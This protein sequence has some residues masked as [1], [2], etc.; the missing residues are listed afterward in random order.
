MNTIRFS[1]I[2]VSQPENPMMSP[3]KN[4]FIEITGD[5][6]KVYPHVVDAFTKQLP[7]SEKPEHSGQLPIHLIYGKHIQH[8]TNQSIKLGLNPNTLKEMVNLL[9]QTPVKGAIK[10][11]FLTGLIGQISKTGFFDEQG[12]PVQ[13]DRQEAIDALL[14]LHSTTC[15]LND[16]ESGWDAQGIENVYHKLLS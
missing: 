9:T 11:L 2:N 1:A 12:Q 16:E 10:I 15:M 4:L 5:D 8:R 3:N 13:F 7:N 6:L 14:Q